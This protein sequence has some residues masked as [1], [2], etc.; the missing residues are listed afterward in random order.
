VDPLLGTCSLTALRQRRSHKWRAY[1]PD[2]LPAFV[3][4]MDFDLA[5][6]IIAAVTSALG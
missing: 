6:P 1:P 5:E 4:E 3:A 2:V